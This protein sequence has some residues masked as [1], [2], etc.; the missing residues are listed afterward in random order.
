MYDLVVRPP[1]NPFL[2]LFLAIRPKQPCAYLI[3]YPGT[4]SMR[5]RC[6]IERMSSNWH[7]GGNFIS[8]L[9]VCCRK[10]SFRAPVSFWGHL[11]AWPQRRVILVFKTPIRTLANRCRQ[12]RELRAN[13][14]RKR[15]GNLR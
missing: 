8:G 13:A 1:D 14:L 6:Q 11:D 5:G 4:I 9:E 2:D 15:R 12:P 3:W 7:T 10:S